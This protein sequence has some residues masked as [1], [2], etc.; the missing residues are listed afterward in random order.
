[1]SQFYNNETTNGLQTPQQG[2]AREWVPTIPPAG[3]PLPFNNDN[4]RT[5]FVRRSD[6]FTSSHPTTPAT[7]RSRQ[8]ERQRSLS[9]PETNTDFGTFTAFQRNRSSSMADTTGP[10]TDRIDNMSPIGPNLV[11][12]E[13]K[14]GL[15]QSLKRGARAKCSGCLRSPS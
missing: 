13:E 6:A 5:P 9:P 8:A 15:L 1:M 7:R 4:G 10:Q 12:D 3:S 14:P 2:P 11:E